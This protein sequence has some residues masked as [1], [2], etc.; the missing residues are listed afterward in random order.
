MDIG[1]RLHNFREASGLIFIVN[2]EFEDFE[3]QRKLVLTRKKKKKKI[4]ITYM[5]FFEE[6]SLL[7]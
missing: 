3:R 4:F 6:D 5:H 7:E 1:N 2:A